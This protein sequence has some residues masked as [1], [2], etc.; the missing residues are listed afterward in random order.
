MIESIIGSLFFEFVGALTKWVVY[1]VHHKV[2]GREVISFREMWDGRKG[3][4]K[5]G[6]IMHGFSNIILGLIVVVGL[7][8]P[9][10]Q[11]RS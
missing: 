4:Q 5:S 6:I 8:V 11:D 7:F 9:S 10:Q 3:S 2:R 1:A